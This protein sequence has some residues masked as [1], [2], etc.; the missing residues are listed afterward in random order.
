MEHSDGVS[1]LAEQ[2][3]GHRARLA[4]LPSLLIVLAVIVTATVSPVPVVGQVLVYVTGVALLASTRLCRVPGT[5]RR[6]NLLLDAPWLPV[7]L[8]AWFIALP[9]AVAVALV[10]VMLVNHL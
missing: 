9:V 5:D 2:P 7:A 1:H 6:F 3:T 4:S 10:P 8:A